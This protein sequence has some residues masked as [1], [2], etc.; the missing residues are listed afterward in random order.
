MTISAR[1]AEIPTQP[2]PIAVIQRFGSKPAVTNKMT[3]PTSGKAGMRASRLTIS[4]SHPVRGIG[5]KRA[6]TLVEPQDEREANCD[7][8]GRQRQ[9]QDEHDLAVSLS[10]AGTRGNESEAGRVQ[11][12]LDRHQHYDEVAAHQDADRPKRKQDH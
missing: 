9:D 2:T 7:F 1:I 3:K 5:I 4:A 8:C 6:E 12:D 11:H 10:P